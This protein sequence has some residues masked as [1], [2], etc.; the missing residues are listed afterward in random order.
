M[1][2]LTPRHVSLLSSV[3]V[4]TVRRPSVACEAAGEAVCAIVGVADGVPVGI[5]M[6]GVV[7]AIGFTDG[8][9]AGA[10]VG[11]A[12]SHARQSQPRIAIVLH[13]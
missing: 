12:Q 13:R 6:G 3:P 5:V 1:S 7:G 4:T 11:M 2:A 8:V 10:R 9:L